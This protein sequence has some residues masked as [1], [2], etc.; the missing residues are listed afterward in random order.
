MLYL[1]TK[2]WERLP[3]QCQTLACWK[4]C[5]KKTVLFGTLIIC[6]RTIEGAA[7]NAVID[8]VLTIWR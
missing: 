2:L 5:V 6:V 4:T 7:T 8:V 1:M 3:P